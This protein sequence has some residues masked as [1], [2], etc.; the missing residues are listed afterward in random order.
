MVKGG[1][2]TA[3]LVVGVVRRR[4]AEG[5]KEEILLRLCTAVRDND[6]FVNYQV[7]YETV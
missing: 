6:F 3:V 5:R 4:P 1:G 7:A 2:G